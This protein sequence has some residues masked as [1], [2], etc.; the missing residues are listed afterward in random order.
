MRRVLLVGTHLGLVEE[1][2]YYLER[3]LRQLGVELSTFDILATAGVPWSLRRVVPQWLKRWL[4]P[5]RLAS[6][7]RT[8]SALR[9][10]SFIRQVERVRPDLVIALRAEHLDAD[11]L[12]AAKA[13][14]AVLINWTADDPAQFIPD[15]IIPEYDLWLLYDRTFEEGLMRRG[16][17]RVGHLPLA[18]DPDLHRPVTLSDAKRQRWGSHMCFVGAYTTR[19]EEL[20]AAVADLG[21][22]IWGPRWEQAT[23]SSVRA[24]VRETRYLRRQEWLQAYCAAELVVSIQSE[25]QQGLSNRVWEALAAGCC[26]VAEWTQELERWL[27]DV[28]AT[29]KTAAEFRAVCQQL[30]VDPEHRRA[31]AAAGR[32]AVLA[33]H[34]Y[35]HRAETLLRCAEECRRP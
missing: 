35:R 6:V 24:C 11:S 10:R 4:S 15:S 16:A 33:A 26:L 28:V 21:L 13:S 34:T 18:C 5:R 32:A 17:K 9:N 27:P 31:R 8:N 30:L 12:R 29:F 22:A 3:G 2:D 23:A 20:F 19:R 7:E 14:G 25:T 1:A